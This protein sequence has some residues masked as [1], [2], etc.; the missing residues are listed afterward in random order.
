M[1]RNKEFKRLCDLSKKILKKRPTLSNLGNPFLFIVSAHPF[2]LSR[3]KSVDSKKIN[4]VFYFKYIF[5]LTINLIKIKLFIIKLIFTKNYL[6][7]NKNFKKGSITVSHLINSENFK[8]NIDTQFAGIEKEIE[9]NKTI[10]FY[11]DHISIGNKAKIDTIKSKKDLFINN[12]C[13]ELSTYKKIIK[14]IIKEFNFLIRKV[15]VSNTNFEKKFYLECSKYLFSLSTIKNIIL[16]YNLEKLIFKNKI[17][18]IVITLEGHPYE[19]LIFLL[20]RIHKIKVFAY[21]TTY[22]TKSHFSMFLNLGI[23]FLPTKILASGKISYDLLRTK[24]HTQKVIL[25]GSNKYKKKL[26]IKK[27][28]NSNCLVIPTGLESETTDLLRLCFESLKKEKDPNC[29]FILRLHPQINKFNF[30]KKNRL[31]FKNEKRIQISNSK[32]IDDIYLCKFVLYGVSSAVVEA[33]QQGLI[34]IHFHDS[35]NNFE[36]DPL[37]QLKRKIIINNSNDLIKL[38]KKRTFFSQKKILRYINFAN[39]FYRPVNYKKLREI[40]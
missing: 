20:G 27:I 10:F 26:K 8:K 22:I 12:N 30:I 1:I 2:I 7:I 13:I 4:F 15:K 5:Q 39:N 23:N 24:F 14:N 38:F 11:L 32:L 36:Y 28:D 35:K 17:T 40:F 19:H 25:L 16:F 21:Q 34:P 3:Y 33:V 29:K 37:W 31:I 9:K 6:N 18:Y